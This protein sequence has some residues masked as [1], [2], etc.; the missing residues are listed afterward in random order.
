MSMAWE[1][2]AVWAMSVMCLFS[3]AAVPTTAPSDSRFDALI[4]QLGDDD[5]Q[6]RQQATAALAKAGSDAK[7]AL[8]RAQDN[9]DPEIRSRVADLLSRLEPPDQDDD[10]PSAADDPQVIILNGGG[11]LIIN[12][13]Q[14]VIPPADRVDDMLLLRQDVDRNMFKSRVDAAHQKLV[15][16]QIAKIELAHS[17]MPEQLAPQDAAREKVIS[18]PPSQYA[19]REKVYLDACDDLRKMLADL[20]LPDP[21]TALPPPSAMRLGVA[22]GPEPEM[23]INSVDTGSRAER[24]GLKVGDSVVSINGKPI[25]SVY[26]LRAIVSANSHLVVTLTRDGKKLTMEEPIPTT[27]LIDVR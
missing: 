11:Q 5:F 13:G 1:K 17:Q 9:S 21:G 8:E 2:W 19:A 12:G 15:R 10:P 7:A 6:T 22:V 26:D 23:I 18:A 4:R 16:E 14:V 3:L 20:K 27:Q 25:T 24:I